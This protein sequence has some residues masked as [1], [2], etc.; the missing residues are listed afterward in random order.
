MAR[1]ANPPPKEGDPVAPMDQA[2][3][4]GMGRGR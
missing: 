4:A 1:A 3:D 2:Q